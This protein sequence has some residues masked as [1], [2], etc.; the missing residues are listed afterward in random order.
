[1][2]REEAATGPCGG[3]SYAHS[4]FSVLSFIHGSP[5]LPT[6]DSLFYTPRPKPLSYSFKCLLAVSTYIA[7]FSS[8]F[9]CFKL[10]YI[11]LTVDDHTTTLFLWA[12]KP[13][14]LSN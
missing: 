2:A 7:G 1:M 9:V 13:T 5:S 4:I 11:H 3:T 8:T 12:T 10:S 6:N 14:S